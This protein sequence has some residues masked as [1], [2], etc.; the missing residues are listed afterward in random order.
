[1]RRLHLPAKTV[2]GAYAY[3]RKDDKAFV[4]HVTICAAMIHRH[5]CRSSTIDEASPAMGRKPCECRGSRKCSTEMFVKCSAAACHRRRSLLPQASR[6]APWKHAPPVCVPMESSE[7]HHKGI[8][9]HGRWRRGGLSPPVPR[10]APLTAVRL[11]ACTEEEMTPQQS[12]DPASFRA[13]QA[14]I[15]CAAVG[16]S[17]LL[18]NCK[19]TL[20]D[21][22]KAAT[23]MAVKTHHE[24]RRVEGAVVTM[25][26]VHDTPAATAGAAD[27]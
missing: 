5:L 19:R 7:N 9:P 20:T 3:S 12:V 16:T 2:Y 11:P 17:Y 27:M 24:T 22:G 1:M 15:A 26:A 6:P 21:I 4:L 8:W 18:H 23:V 10:P 13:R 14:G 25:R